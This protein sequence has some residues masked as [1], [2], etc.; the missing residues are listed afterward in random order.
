[1]IAR[2]AKLVT[3]VMGFSYPIWGCSLVGTGHMVMSGR[4]EL[5]LISGL[6]LLT[7]ASSLLPSCVSLHKPLSH[8][9]SRL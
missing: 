9:E 1:M 5:V 3:G 4:R 6:A 8:S 7:P 2:S